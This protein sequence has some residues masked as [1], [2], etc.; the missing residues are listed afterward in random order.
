MLALLLARIGE[1]VAVD[2]LIHELWAGEPPRTARASLQ[3][4]VCQLR[5]VL[6]ANALLTGNESYALN[7]EPERL[8]IEQFRLIV[9]R[10]RLAATAESRA[11]MLRAALALWRGPAFV[12]VA[13]TPSLAFEASLL[14]E[15]RISALEDVIDAELKLGYATEV[16]PELEQLIADE[17]YR[18]RLRA[19]LML[20][21]YRTGRQLRALEVF[22]E[23]R[24]TLLLGLGLEP[25][26]SLRQLERA[27]LNH[28][29]LLAGNDLVPR[30]KQ[31]RARVF[32]TGRPHAST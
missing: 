26:P 5:K 22:K 12:D 4:S 13:N 17:P 23:A 2:W 7:V 14:D 20:A 24:E 11:Q 6:G 10:S 9:C 21:L 25:S 27:I 8:D 18:E 15:L 30:P 16:V 32:W 3:N 19:Q 29:P 28:D 1:F 31:A